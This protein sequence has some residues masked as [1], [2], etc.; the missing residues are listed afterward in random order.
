MIHKIWDYR[1]VSGKEEINRIKEAA[2]PVRERY[3]TYINSTYVGGGVAEIMHS[4]VLLLNSV[5]VRTAWRMFKGSERFFTVTKKFHNALQGE[6]VDFSEKDR[7]AYLEETEKN[8]IMNF[9][10]ADDLVVVHDPQAVAMINHYNRVQPWIWR[11]HIDITQPFQPVWDFLKPSIKKY[12]GV[13]VSMEEYKKDLGI[14]Q[15]IIPPSINPLNAK[16]RELPEKRTEALLAEKGIDTDKP[17]ITQVS[18]FDKWKDP[19]GVIGIFKKARE[20]VPGLQLAMVG[21]FAA[22]DPEGPG[23]FKKLNERARGEPGIK[24]ITNAPDEFVN[25]VQARSS[26]VIQNSTREGFGMTVTEALWKGTPVV[27]RP[28]GGIPLQVLD[29]QTGFLAS[30]PDEAAARC[31]ELAQNQALREKLGAQAREHVRN[32]FLITRQLKDYLELFNKY[33]G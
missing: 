12:D 9:F 17:L 30:T 27:A 18:R 2:D 15:F 14:P 3:V 10:G 8:C 1:E 5:G 33:I 22:D 29:G 24:I 21:D 20:K 19:L 11:C 26:A 6:K 28:S 25:A 4:L 23:M 7:E 32:H 31:I 13:I 16:N